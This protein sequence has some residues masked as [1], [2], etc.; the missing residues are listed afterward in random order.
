MA[1]GVGTGQPGAESP[2]RNS[3]GTDRDEGREVRDLLER[4]LVDTER[5]GRAVRLYFVGTEETEDALEELGRER[6][7]FRFLELEVLDG[8]PDRVLVE[9]TGPAGAGAVLDALECNL[10]EAG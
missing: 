7:C 4:A 9:A 5:S 3:S 1:A 2:P 10:R 6:E 8:D